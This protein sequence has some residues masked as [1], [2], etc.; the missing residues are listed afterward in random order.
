MIKAFEAVSPARCGSAISRAARLILPGALAGLAFYAFSLPVP[1]AGADQNCVSLDGRFE[2]GGLVQGQ[3]PA[4]LEVAVNGR[5]IRVAPDGHFIFGFGRDAPATAQLSVTC[6]G[7]QREERQLAVAQRRY[8][9]QRIDGLPR[10]MVTPPA[11]VLARIRRENARIAQLRAADRPQAHYR[12][13]FIWPVIG[14]ITGVFG[15]QRILNGEPKR[16]H[17]GIDIAAPTGTP[18]VAPADGIVTLAADDLYY[19]GGTVLLDH[20][21]GLTSVYSHLESVSVTEGGFVAQ[22]TQI[23][24]LGGTG[25]ATGPHLDWRINW[26]TER[27]DPAFFVPPMPSE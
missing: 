20:G 8:E 1:E 3:G 18:I 17:Y 22:G 15:S 27:L 5:P 13:G 16:P 23:G 11:E 9:T 26:F 14:R 12:S 6:P 10:K 2:Q 7:G 19:T 24:T 4:G 21:F 25:R